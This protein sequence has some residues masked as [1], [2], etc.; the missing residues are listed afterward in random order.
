M[1]VL[2]VEAVPRAGV[3]VVFAGLLDL[4]D[5]SAH[6]AQLADGGRAGPR[7]AEVDDPDVG[8]GQGI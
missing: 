6:V 4:D 7:P 8:Q 5:L 1:E 2:E 3:A